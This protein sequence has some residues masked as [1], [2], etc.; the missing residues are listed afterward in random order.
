MNEAFCNDGFG[1]DMINRSMY[2]VD[3]NIHHHRKN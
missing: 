3:E 1:K 2:L